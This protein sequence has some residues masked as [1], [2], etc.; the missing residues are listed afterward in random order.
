MT[1]PVYE[2]CI[3]S[4]EEK[5]ACQH[6]SGCLAREEVTTKLKPCPFCG[7]P[8]KVFG[9]NMVGCEDVNGC[10]GNVDF[11]HWVGY[12]DDGTPAINYVIEQWNKRTQ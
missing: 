11:G 2:R 10:G 5:G 9:T 7:G 6:P 3:P 8:A 4:C 1:R 12:A